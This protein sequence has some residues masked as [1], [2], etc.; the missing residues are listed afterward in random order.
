MQV[1]R[2]VWIFGVLIYAWLRLTDGTAQR[3]AQVVHFSIRIFSAQPV[4]MNP[5]SVSS[6]E[7]AKSLHLTLNNGLL[8]SNSGAK[9]HGLG[10]KVNSSSGMFVIEGRES[11]STRA[12]LSCPT[13]SAALKV[14]VVQGDSCAIVVVQNMNSHTAV[15]VRRAGVSYE[16]SG[17]PTSLLHSHAFAFGFLLCNRL[18]IPCSRRF[19]H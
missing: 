13:M 15:E 2:S 10:Q 19:S 5:L 3:L 12:A 17:V 6:N 9:P 7:F 14:H 1:A 4:E 8:T 11:T 16:A 18:G